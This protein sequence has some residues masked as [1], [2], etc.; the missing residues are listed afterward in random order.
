[1]PGIFLGAK[2]SAANKAEYTFIERRQRISEVNRMYP[3]LDADKY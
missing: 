2:N 3:T 1:M